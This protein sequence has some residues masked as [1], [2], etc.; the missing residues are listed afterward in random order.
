VISC[1]ES[2]FAELRSG[3][4]DASAGHSHQSLLSGEPGIGKTRPADE[5]G[6]LAV[7]PGVRLDWGQCWEGRCTPAYWPWMQAIRD[8]LADTDAEQRAAILG[9]SS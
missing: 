5:F 8:C 9:W 7:D 3:L 2:E 1:R 4:S 6:R